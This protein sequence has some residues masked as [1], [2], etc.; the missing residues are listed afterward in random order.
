VINFK[1][2][3]KE[4]VQ[5]PTQS[6]K[7]AQ[8]ENITEKIQKVLALANNNPNAQES[9]AAFLKAR[10]LM[11]RY[12]IEYC[13]S[14][15]DKASEIAEAMSEG[16]ISVKW[17]ACLAQVIREN[18]GVLAYVQ[19]IVKKRRRVD[20]AVFMGNAERA[21]AAA[22][23]FAHAQKYV[24]KASKTYSSEYRAK[25]GTSKGVRTTYIYAWIAGLSR[26]YEEQSEQFAITLKP[27]KEVQEALDAAV[28]DKL[29]IKLGSTSYRSD[30]KI[31]DAGNTD[32]YLYGHK[33]YA[34]APKGDS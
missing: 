23:V 28:P 26:R 24:L 3:S 11:L 33:M 10:E 5:A 12:E 22:R 1:K 9:K 18:F 25:Y 32:G 4:P 31:K 20:F 8:L 7:G 17:H 2:N 34:S 30:Q 29:D 15:T 14:R 16:R 21:E 27:G 19:G 13:E 6:K